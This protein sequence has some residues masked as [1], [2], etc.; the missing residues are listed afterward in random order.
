M[1]SILGSEYNSEPKMLWLLSKLFL[2]VIVS[3]Y[4]DAVY[5][6]SSIIME[7]IKPAIATLARRSG[8]GFCFE[9]TF[10]FCDLF[11][12]AYS[13]KL[14]ILNPLLHGL[15]LNN[16]VP[17]G[18]IFDNGVII[19]SKKK[20]VRLSVRR[21]YYWDVLSVKRRNESWTVMTRAD[22]LTYC[23]YNHIQAL[24]EQILRYK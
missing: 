16:T 21:N 19:I 6:S 10:S 15:I 20:A 1:K 17:K 3:M 8:M 23:S 11:A 12:L 13:L 4:T 9:F 18:P 14:W 22:I 24:Q 7:A 2:A 5:R